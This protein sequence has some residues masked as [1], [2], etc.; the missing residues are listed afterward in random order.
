M[1]VN[2]LIKEYIEFFKSKKHKEIKN[3]SLIPENDPTALFISA[4]MHPLVPY[5]LGQKHPFG[6]RLV[7]VQR[8]IRTTDIEEVGDDVHLTFFEMLGNWSLGDYFKE[9]AI[10]FSFEFLTKVLK[11]NK[12]KLA[13]SCFIGDENAEKDIESA[14]VWESLGI[15]KERIKFLGKRDNWWGPAGSTGP[16]GPDT[17]MFY[18]TGKE[19]APR[20]FNL[21]DKTWVEIWNDVFMQYNQLKDGSLKELKQKNVDTGMGVERT[22]MTLNNLKSVFETELF[23]PLINKI[24]EFSKKDDTKAERI[25]ADHIK[26]SVFILNEKIE[27]SNLGRGYVLRRL[28]RRVIRYG[29]LIGIRKEN[30]LEDLAKVV[31]DIYKLNYPE[32]KKNEIFILDQLKK[33]D[34]RFRKSLNSGLRVFEKEI[35]KLEEK[36][37]S[38]ETAFTLF[39]SYGFPLEMTIELAKEKNLEVDEENFWEE[40]KKHQEL[41]RKATKGVFKSGLADNSEVVTQLHTVAHLLLQALRNHIDK[42]I[43]QRGSNITAERIRFDFN[44]DRKLEDDEIKVIENEV[45]EKI[46][47]SLEVKK[48]E[49]SVEEAKKKGASGTFE[50]KYGNVVSVYSIGNYSEEICA[51]PHVSNTKEIK[52]KFRIIKQESSGAGIRRIKAV[53]EK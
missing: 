34:D 13:V 28:I 19:N 8:C 24:R 50:E 3:S 10:K 17:E 48:E 30:Y 21:E 44:L 16:C 27:P 22:I 47:A 18:W 29:N 39:S 4:G 15:P 42:N 9:D 33:E 25:I 23:S 41:S 35:R 7:N 38:G 5:L 20:E 32:L 45:N 36:I 52:G 1:K 43:E 2:E 6:N 49:M 26:A 51:G 31:I 53:L 14:E 40:F 11:L 46:K 12:N 37:L